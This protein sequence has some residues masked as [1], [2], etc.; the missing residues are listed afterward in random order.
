MDYPR[1]MLEFAAHLVVSAALILVVG[2]VVRGFEVEGA[3][4]ALLAALALGVVNTF[5]KPV[6]VLLTLPLTLLTF[7]LFYLV[8]NALMLRLAAALVPGFRIR[9][10]A[11]AF[12]GALLLALLNLAVQHLVGR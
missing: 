1:S 6:A 10:F 7:G 5:V 11:P 4:P 2:A 3:A 12:W 8:V 9:G